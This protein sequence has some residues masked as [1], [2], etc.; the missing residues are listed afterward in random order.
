MKKGH[1]KHAQAQGNVV[2]LC[3]CT[4]RI[5]SYLLDV[6]LMFSATERSL[7]IEAWSTDVYAVSIKFSLAFI[8]VRP[9][10]HYA[11]QHLHLDHFTLLHKQIKDISA[12]RMTTSLILCY[13]ETSQCRLFKIKRMARHF[14]NRL[15]SHAFQ[16]HL[17]NPYTRMAL[18]KMN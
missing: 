14:Y 9:V 3:F 10:V 6:C 18:L 17:S 8:M 1:R 7:F 15:I 13:R 12:W 4:K 11:S 5:K 2:Q 16:L